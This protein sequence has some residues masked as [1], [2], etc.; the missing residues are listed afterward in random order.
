MYKG[1]AVILVLCM[2]ISANFA[3]DGQS[4]SS[5]QELHDSFILASDYVTPAF[6]DIPKPLSL[7]ADTILTPLGWIKADFGERDIEI[8]ID[9]DWQYITL[10]EYIDDEIFRIPFTAPMDWY[11]NN[12]INIKRRI[13]FSEKV[14]IGSKDVAVTSRRGGKGITFDLVDMGALGTASL[15]VR[16]NINISGKMVFQDQELI[17][18][19]LAES[20]NTHLEF[21]QKQNLNVEGKIGDRITVLMDNDSERDFDWENNI[22]ISYEGAE[23]DIIQKIDAGNI[24]LS[25]P[26]TQYVTFSGKNK[27]LFGLKAVSKLGPIDITMIASIEKTKKGQLEYEGTSDAQ[28][29]RINDYDYIRYQYFFINTL[30]RNGVQNQPTEYMGQ[31]KNIQY[32]P[33]FYPLKGGLHRIGRYAV[34]NFELYRMDN[35][36]DPTSEPGSA[37]VDINNPSD[38]DRNNV[39]FKRLEEG[40]DYS[41]SRDLGY[42][43]L[44]NRSADKVIA[45]HYLI[46]ELDANNRDN[47][48][49]LY[50][51]PSPRD[52]T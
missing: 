17:R 49:L 52:V 47:I 29:E 20:Q 15:R 48:C 3:Q 36:T 42:L 7:L 9:R 25:L 46:V 10:T 16:G 28:T 5:V 23:D 35:S 6:P 8:H 27:G 33:P 30:Y 19:S 51:S 39:K 4:D 37:M 43:R 44:R 2:T 45:C 34:R 12:M 26:S 14:S 31:S 11:F 1:Y 40:M 24:S 13:I 50:P 38:Y 32:I 41:I 21:D 18:S 22:R